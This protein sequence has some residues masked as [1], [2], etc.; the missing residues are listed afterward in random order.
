M[1]EQLETHLENIIQ[2]LQEMTD[3]LNRSNENKESVGDT[4]FYKDVEDGILD[5][6]I[7][8]NRKQ[9]NTIMTVYKFIYYGEF[10]TDKDALRN[11]VTRR[12]REKNLNK[13]I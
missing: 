1:N 8:A 2:N 7:N 12:V 4:Q 6:M 5:N 10:N 13:L 11:E 9:F 3:I